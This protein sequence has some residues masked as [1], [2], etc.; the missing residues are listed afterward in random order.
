MSATK[1][2]KKR[3]KGKLKKVLYLYKRALGL[4]WK[5]LEFRIG[6]KM[7]VVGMNG[8]GKSTF[9]K[10]LCRLYDPTE[11]TITMNGIDIRRYDYQEY[12]SLFSVVFQDFQLFSFTLGE[13]VAVSEDYQEEAVRDALGKAGMEE[14]L[15]NHENSLSTV[16]VSGFR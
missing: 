7:A 2:R 9:I 5:N 15:E 3:E 14:F 12:M 13:N 6:E 11:G 8:S 1:E 16:F 4:M 10:L